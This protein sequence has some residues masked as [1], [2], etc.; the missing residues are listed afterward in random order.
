MIDRE[1]LL[2]AADALRAVCRLDSKTLT[3]LA[4]EHN[5]TLKRVAADVRWMASG[6]QPYM[7]MLTVADY[8]ERIAEGAPG[9]LNVN[10]LPV[11]EGAANDLERLADEPAVPIGPNRH[12]RRAA[13][14]GK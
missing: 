9:K 4:L 1:D 7:P 8:L 10:V 12:Q 14:A 11:L 13:A 3:K 5:A 2:V 6:P